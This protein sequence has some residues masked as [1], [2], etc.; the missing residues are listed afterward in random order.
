MNF[1]RVLIV[2]WGWGFLG[3]S[4]VF[5]FCCVG[6]ERESQRLNVLAFLVP[7]HLAANAYLEPNSQSLQ[8]TEEGGGRK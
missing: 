2:V 1:V 3:E 4:T 6:G 5:Q 8:K 7:P